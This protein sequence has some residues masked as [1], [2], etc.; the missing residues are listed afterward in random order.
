MWFTAF[1]DFW[2][3]Y[4]RAGDGGDGDP[5]LIEIGRG[6][7]GSGA[8]GSGAVVVWFRRGEDGVTHDGGNRYAPPYA[9]WLSLQMH[10][11][12][13]LHVAGLGLVVSC[14]GVDGDHSS[15]R[16]WAPCS[17]SLWWW[18]GGALGPYCLFPPELWVA[19]EEKRSC[20]RFP[21]AISA[22]FLGVNSFL[23]VYKES[24]MSVL[25]GMLLLLVTKTGITTR[26]LL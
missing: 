3:D 26:L 2:L 17:S 8:M 25:L 10:S 13:W 19:R 18:S 4:P 6:P 20:T 24:K 22:S 16:G 5:S 21:T 15:T 11:S 9:G 1:R 23:E 12:I 14:A 7:A